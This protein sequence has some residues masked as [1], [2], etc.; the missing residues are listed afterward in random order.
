MTQESGEGEIKVG[1]N[2][3]GSRKYKIDV[4]KDQ[5]KRLNHQFL[6]E[7]DSKS[8]ERSVS[9][10]GG[11]QGSKVIH[12]SKKGSSRVRIEKVCSNTFSAD[13]FS[14]KEKFI[15][16]QKITHNEKFN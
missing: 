8:L 13:S 14:S 12:V 2:T 4:T 7:E 1:D 9:S 16:N 5:R 11:N 10:G 6:M 3:G 15:S